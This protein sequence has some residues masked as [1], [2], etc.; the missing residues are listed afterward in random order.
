MSAAVQY[1]YFRGLIG[2]LLLSSIGVWLILRARSGDTLFLGGLLRVS[3]WLL[4]LV[5]I[6]L[7]CPTIWYLYLGF[8]A[9]L[10]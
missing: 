5:G 9:D 2:P 7:Q 3:P 4:S 6:A 8:R 1:A 10:F